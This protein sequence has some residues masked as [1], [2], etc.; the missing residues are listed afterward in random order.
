[1]IESGQADVLIDDHTVRRIGVGGDFGE[2]A[3]LRDTRGRRP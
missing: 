2:R 1:V 3:L